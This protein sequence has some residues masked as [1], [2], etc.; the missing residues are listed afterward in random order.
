[1]IKPGD[2]IPLITGRKFWESTDPDL[3][4]AKKDVSMLVWLAWMCGGA[5]S[6]GITPRRIARMRGMGEA[7][8]AKNLFV[9]AGDGYYVHKLSNESSSL[10]SSPTDRYVVKVR[11]RDPWGVGPI[12][13][14]THEGEF[15]RCWGCRK[16]GRFLGWDGGNNRKKT[17]N[18]AWTAYYAHG[19][20]RG[21][22]LSYDVKY[23]EVEIAEKEE[24]DFIDLENEEW[25]NYA[26]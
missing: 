15:I 25:D 16:F 12:P 23:C 20:G 3:K 4:R 11:P 7:S 18:G 10:T 9:L 14:P 21:G 2:T 26:G 22:L 17:K 24:F 19:V 1:M 8:I 6:R 5:L 13:I